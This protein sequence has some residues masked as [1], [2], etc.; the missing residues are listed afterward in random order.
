[1]SGANPAKKKKDDGSGHRHKNMGKFERALK[2]RRERERALIEGKGDIDQ[3][4][5]H[6][7][8]KK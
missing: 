6:R 5:G 3:R 7:K 2:L 8:K 1:M 4:T